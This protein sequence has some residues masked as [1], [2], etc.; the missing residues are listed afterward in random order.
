MM[1]QV[2]IYDRTPKE[3]IIRSIGDAD[4]VLTNKT[5]LTGETLKACPGSNILAVSPPDIMWLT[6][7]RPMPSVLS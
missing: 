5:P 3:E 6:L 4:I 1:G 2:S 7:R